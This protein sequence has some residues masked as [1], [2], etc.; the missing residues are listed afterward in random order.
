MVDLGRHDVVAVHDPE[1]DHRLTAYTQHEKFAFTGEVDRD[2]EQF[3]DVLLCEHVGAC[4]DIADQWHVSNGSAI[5]DGAAVRI[6]S[7]FDGSGLVRVTP[8]VAE[9]LQGVQV[10]VHR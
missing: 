6:E 9:P 4:S 1:L 2:G 10:A 7:H 8:Q 3:F 5:H